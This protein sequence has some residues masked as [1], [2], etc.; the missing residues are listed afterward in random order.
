V[1]PVAAP[2]PGGPGPGR[3]RA[4]GVNRSIARLFILLSGA[5]AV[6]ALLL[7]YWQVVAAPSLNDRADN[8]QAAQRERLIDRGRIISGDRVV[9]ARSVAV[10]RGGQDVFVRGYPN[11][12]LAP[13][14]VGYATPQQGNTGLESQYDGFL[15]GD[16]GTEPLLVRLRLR[17]ARGADVRT[18]LD[19]RVQRVANEQLI[20][21]RGAVVALEP[22]TGRI[23]AMASSPGFDL[24]RVDT[25]FARI[26][27]E[28]NAPL[29]NR[30]TA[31]R[32]A[33][34]S[35]FKVV[36][37]VAALESDLGYS[38][39]SEFDDTGRLEASGRPITNFGG[40]VFGRHTLTEALTFSV[41]TTFARLG[42]VLGQER[43]GRTM[44]AFGFG[45]RPPVDLP[46][47]EVAASGRYRGS[48]LL[49]NG[50]EGI[51]VA[52]VGIG[53]EQLGVTPLQMAMV[54]GT[55]ANGCTL[56]R[57]HL[58][59]RI[60]DRGGAVVRENRPSELRQVCS[61]ETAAQVTQ[62]MRNVVREGT[63][64]AAALGG[65]DVAGKTGT[66]ETQTPGINNAWFIGFAPAAAPR[67]AVAVVVEAT[68][69]TGGV[70]AAPIARQVME[71]AIRRSG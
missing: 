63:G 46:E 1:A 70:E 32:Y 61:A 4:A 9:L 59:D 48:T 26:R 18:T 20:G 49:P 11:G 50:E 21:R 7:G 24:D 62:M 41:N 27:G 15:K 8:P 31:G 2:P 16:Y 38:P 30:A 53:Q 3:G 56:M 25:E 5:F 39:T 37:A 28:G 55:I 43:L 68:T 42:Q 71:A 35:T 54:A 57:P 14:V 51:D 45:S 19:S 65:L 22:R 69:G 36:T 34:G 52:R 58:M 33:P 13:H 29:L 64:T 66:A 67:V 60:T 6:L 44:E 47:S 40:R 17:T 10:R 12:T 23:L